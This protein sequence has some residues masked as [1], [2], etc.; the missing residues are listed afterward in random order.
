MGGKGYSRGQEIRIIL[1]RDLARKVLG[2]ELELVAGRRLGGQ[3]VRLLAEQAQRVGLVDA[4]ALGGADAVPAPLP[5]LA[6]ADLGG[7]GVLLP[8]PLVAAGRG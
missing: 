8:L 1:A 4:A 7:G 2:R 5:Q 6:A 3:L